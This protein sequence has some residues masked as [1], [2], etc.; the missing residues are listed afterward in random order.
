MSGVTETITASKDLLEAIKTPSVV[1]SLDIDRWD[2]L[3]RQA[4]RTRLL[5]RIAEQTVDNGLLQR[6]PPKVSDI[7]IAARF[8]AAAN[9]RMVAWEASQIREILKSVDTPIV[10]LKGAAYV[11]SNLPLA[12]GRISGDIDIL[13]PRAVLEDVENALLKCDWQHIKM[14]DY[15]QRYYRSWMHELPPL[16]HAQR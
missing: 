3:I 7:L 6:V 10:L 2:L 1:A 11:A 16:R 5:S 12:R 14:S 9:R 13:V 4:R 15:D 8:V